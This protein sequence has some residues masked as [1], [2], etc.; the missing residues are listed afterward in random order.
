MRKQVHM[1]GRRI[2]VFIAA[3]ACWAAGTARLG[4]SDPIGVYA[5]IEKVVFEPAQGQPERVQVWGAFAL[6]DTRNN[7]DYGT[8]QK[9]YLYF[10]CPPQQLATCR[11][12]WADLQSVAGKGV[13]VGFGGRRLGNG[14]VRGATD[15]PESPD[16]YP[17]RMGVYRTEGRGYQPPVIQQL[18]AALGG[19]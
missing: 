13:G 11:N 1:N 9:G 8:P 19:R 14:R 2:F 10:S 17:I 5:V 6:S 12:E 16:P 3:L 4:A 18:K 7:D 15:K